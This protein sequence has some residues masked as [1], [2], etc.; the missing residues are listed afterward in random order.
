[1][2]DGR[3]REQLQGIEEIGCACGVPEEKRDLRAADDDAVELACA[4]GGE[5]LARGVGVGVVGTAFHHVIDSRVQPAPQLPV[6]RFAPHVHGQQRLG[7]D[8]RLPEAEDADVP[9]RAPGDLRQG[10]VDHAQQIAAG[11]LLELRLEQVDEVRRD[12]DEV[13][14]MTEVRRG[15]EKVGMSPEARG[16]GPGSGAAC[17]TNRQ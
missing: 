11:S 10:Q 3:F 9:P 5:R 17:G 2:L 8:Q 4:Q 16:S 13:D 15:A 6:D 12:H 7:V 14:E 1:M